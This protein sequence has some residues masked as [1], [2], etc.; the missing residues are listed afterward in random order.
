[1]SAVQ[2]LRHFYRLDSK[3]FSRDELLIV[4]IVLFS[5]LCNELNTITQH[6]NHEL[7]YCGTIT[8]EMQ[9]TDENIVKCLINDLIQSGEYSLP[10]IANYTDTPEDVVYEIASGLNTRPSLFLAR[11]VI[12]LHKEARK[13]IYIKILHKVIEQASLINEKSPL[14]V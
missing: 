9:M 13:D 10:G 14:P 2:E 1:M 11:K 5:Y 8:K 4:E 12:D 7:R 6:T 3:G